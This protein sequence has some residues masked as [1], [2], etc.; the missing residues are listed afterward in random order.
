MII[1]FFLKYCF[2]KVLV[3]EWGNKKELQCTARKK[4]MFLMMAIGVFKIIRAVIQMWLK[5][6]VKR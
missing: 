2:L 3:S 5:H 4:N 6:A 1:V